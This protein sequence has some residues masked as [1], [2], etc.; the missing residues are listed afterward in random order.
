M[1]SR[2]CS[3]DSSPATRSDGSS[4]TQAAY[5]SGRASSNSAMVRP[6][7]LPTSYSRRRGSGSTVSRLAAATY[8]AVC[9]ARARSLDHSRAGPNAASTGATVAACARP[10]AFSGTSA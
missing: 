10:T 1:R 5:S 2:T 3:V 6:E 8:A 7:R 9:M 4:A